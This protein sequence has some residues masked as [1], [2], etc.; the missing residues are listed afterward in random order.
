VL[1]AQT[2]SRREG[3]TGRKKEDGTKVVTVITITI[4]VDV[5]AVEHSIYSLCCKRNI[6]L[7]DTV[8]LRVIKTGNRIIG[9]DLRNARRS[10]GTFSGR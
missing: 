1:G 4:R 5:V 3:P 8:A 10:Y 2:R 9:Q 7:D 6:M